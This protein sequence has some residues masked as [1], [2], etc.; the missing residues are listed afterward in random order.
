MR[1]FVTGGHGFVGPHLLAHLEESG[2]EVVAPHQDDV[3]LDDQDA[4]TKAVL[5]AKPDAIYHLAALAHVGESWANPAR[6]FDVNAVGTLRLLEAA[7]LLDVK[8]RVLLIGSAEVYGP[9]TPDDVPIEE[10]RPLYPVTPYAVSKVAAEYLGV[11]YHAGFGV[12]VVRAR[13]FNHVGPGQQRARFLV[14]D[15]ASRIAEAKKTGESVL[16]VGNTTPRR[17][18]TDVRDVVRAYRLLITSG[19]AGEAYNVCSG[20]DVSV[21][22]LAHRL[23]ELA[24]VDLALE[25][26]PS[27]L[28]PVDVPVLVGSNTKL[29][30]A[31]GWSP[32]YSLDDTL[33]DVLATY[34][35]D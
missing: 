28:R 30:A 17:D 7:R 34:L 14:S 9:V 10:S 33:R 25:T 21:E 22:Q 29:R 35:S 12:P 19:V 5:D 26:D 20:V 27:L 8:P 11:Q 31:T 18:Y 16:R 6:T 13:S 15:L 1:A 2:D 23:L 4:I 3:D 24:G 32:S